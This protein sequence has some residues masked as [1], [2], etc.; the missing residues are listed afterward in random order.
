MNSIVNTVNTVTV[1]TVTVPASGMMLITHLMSQ[2]HAP[3]LALLG[4]ARQSFPR[5]SP[6][7]VTVTA[8][9][10][11]GVVRGAMRWQRC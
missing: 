11:L 5:R 1:S 2:V 6:S 9:F 3:F 7:T 10:M 4:V 8:S